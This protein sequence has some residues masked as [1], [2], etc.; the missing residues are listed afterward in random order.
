MKELLSISRAMS[1]LAALGPDRPAITFGGRTVTR[2]QLDRRTNRTARAYAARARRPGP[3]AARPDAAGRFVTI[4]LPNGI[5]FFEAVV[6]VWKL[7]GTPHLVSSRMPPAE[8]TALVELADPALVVGEAPAAGRPHIGAGFEP[9]P[10]LSDAELPDRVSPSWKAMCSGGSTG[11]PKLIVDARPGTV[12][13]DGPGVA[14]LLPELTQ[15]VCG[16]L[17]HNSA[18]FWG[19]QGL[20]IGHHLVV[21]PRFDAEQVLAAIDRHRIELAVF[22]PTMMRRIYLLPEDVKS[23]YDVSSLRFVVHTAARCPD[24]LKQ[25]WIDWLGP[26][27]IWETYSG[28]ENIAGTAIRGDEWLAHRGSVGRLKHGRIRILDAAGNDVPA[29]DTGEIFMQS[30]RP[31]YR[32]IGASPAG[33]DG[34]HSLGD[35]GRLDADGYLYIADRRTDLILRGGANVF[36]AE[37]EAALDRH[38]QVAESVV[39]GVP[40]DDLGERVHAIVR[41]GGALSEAELRAFMSTQLAS[42]KCPSTYEFVDAPLRDEVGKARR[43][44]YRR[45]AGRLDRSDPERLPRP[46]GPP[47][48]DNTD[49]ERLPQMRPPPA[50]EGN[51]GGT[52]SR[53]NTDPERLPGQAGRPDG[54]G[55]GG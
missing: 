54:P 14:G 49:P 34:W 31:T 36:P 37:V 51:P 28:T 21:L 26:K 6:A 55:P 13:P 48:R 43:A 2:A 17:Y 16:P 41:P 45:S 9:E 38:P 44:R 11:A 40:D 24:W 3:D 19:S 20:H 33:R 12:D 35:L 15:L 30:D 32:Y 18:F 10:A 52:P 47:P 5:E 4:A 25:A 50:R 46:G 8:Q 23:R 42:Y 22:A 1:R 53:G 29:G 39:V 7:G 27:K